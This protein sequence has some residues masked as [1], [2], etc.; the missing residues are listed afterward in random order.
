MLFLLPLLVSPLF[1]FAFNDIWSLAFFIAGVVIASLLLWF[2]QTIGY[3]YYAEPGQSVQLVTRSP[4]FIV[5]MLPVTL[6]VV[7]S[8]GSPLGMGLVLAMG[9]IICSELW[10]WRNNL[11]VLNNRFYV[12]TDKNLTHT[13]FTW[14]T[15]FLTIF[16]MVMAILVFV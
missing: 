15:R 1:Y 9:A 16:F 8:S 5:V 12:K 13:E 7:T 4:L 11:E 3:Q 6:F 2:D 14:I 10:W